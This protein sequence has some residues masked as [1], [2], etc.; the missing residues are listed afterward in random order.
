[1]RRRTVVYPWHTGKLSQ[2]LRLLVVS[3]LH[4]KEYEDILPMLPEG[5]ALLMPGDAVDRY[6][7]ETRLSLAFI[8]E[9]AQVLPTFVGVGNHEMRLENFYD[10][11][12]AVEETGATLLFNSYVRL[13]ELV[14]GCWYRP[15]EYGYRN[16]LPAMEKESGVR[17]LMCHRPEDYMKRLRDTQ[18]DLV[19]AGHAHGGQ[20]RLFGQGLYAPGQGIFPKYTYGVTDNRMII[21]SGA[22]NNVHV[23]RIG[24]PCEVL[25]INLD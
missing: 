25:L 11:R 12:T 7:Q 21:S 18:V 20:I 4:D 17:V 9:A 10:F 14:V 23:P 15:E 16:I 19:L 5:D 3:D 13:G 24:N 8:R 22:S 1:L 6:R 2:P